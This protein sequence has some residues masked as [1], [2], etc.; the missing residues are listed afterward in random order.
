MTAHVL[1]TQMYKRAEEA[2]MALHSAAKC[3]GHR[4]EPSMHAR[5][6]GSVEHWHQTERHGQDSFGYSWDPLHAE[7][8]AAQQGWHRLVVHTVQRESLSGL[9]HSFDP[10]VEIHSVPAVPAPGSF[11]AFELAYSGPQPRS[12]VNAGRGGRFTVTTVYYPAAT[13]MQCRARLT[14]ETCRYA[15]DYAHDGTGGLDP[16]CR[17]SGG[18][19]TGDTA[20]APQ[21]LPTLCGSTC[22]L[23]SFRDRLRSLL[24]ESQPELLHAPV[25]VLSERHFCVE[26][27][28]TGTDFCM[29]RELEIRKLDGDNDE[30]IGTV[31]LVLILVMC[32]VACL[33]ACVLEAVCSNRRKRDS[34]NDQSDGDDLQM[35]A[36]GPAQIGGGGGGGELAT[37]HDL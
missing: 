21:V 25:D 5:G 28:N 26:C 2:A 33:V 3:G 16:V 30:E 24:Q 23:V 32:C 7:V 31:S 35:E 20:G 18:V 37:G 27:G 6:S 4:C 9:L 8:H 14:E 13:E 11:L 34:G 19:C 36:V 15:S 10:H 12:P 17:W 1:Q 22:E 29:E